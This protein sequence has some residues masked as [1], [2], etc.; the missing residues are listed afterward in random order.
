MKKYLQF[1][2]ENMKP[3]LVYYAFDVDDNILFMPTM[4]HMKHLVNG[5]WIDESVSTE[6]FAKVRTD[7]DNWKC[8]ETS[9]R[10]FRDFGPRGDEQFLYDLKIAID[11]KEFGPSWNAFIKC[12]LKGSV[13]LIVTARGHGPVAIRKGIEYII[14]NILTEEEQ[15][16]MASNLISFGDLFGDYDILKDYD[17]EIL[18]DNYLDNCEFI[19]VS[20]PNFLENNKDLVGSNGAANPEKS[21]ERAI[22][23]FIQKINKWGKQV[24]FNVK[25]GFSDDDIRNVDFI[26]RYFN[27][28][29]DFY[30][31]NFY[32]IDTHDKNIEGGIKT[33]I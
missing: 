19:G 5:E 13:F 12:L 17:F 16:E 22:G 33:K 25:L 2:K 32:I 9:F 15:H 26:K 10:D 30:D 24:G 23:N 14:Y 27:E 3:S 31:I 18:I 7:I 29:K 28:N 1:I 11:N 6:E 4:I 20:S 21:K 8:H